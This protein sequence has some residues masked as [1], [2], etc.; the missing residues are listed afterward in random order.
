MMK[1]LANQMKAQLRKQVVEDDLESVFSILLEITANPELENLNAFYNDI[2]SSSAHYYSIRQSFFQRTISHEN[3]EMEK[4]RSRQALLNY[5]NQIDGDE[6]L[7]YARKNTIFQSLLIICKKTERVTEMKKLFPEHRWP[8]VDFA[9]TEGQ[10]DLEQINSY[11]IVIYDNEPFEETPLKVL[12]IIQED[13]PKPLVLCYSKRQ[14]KIPQELPLRYLFANSPFT[15]HARLNDL[16][17]YL[18]N[19]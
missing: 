7:S 14:M 17:L 15:I 18:K 13:L 16:I 4:A 19:I 1:D 11:G 2:L 6:L 5:I 9:E 8:F 12:D 3:H 10:Y